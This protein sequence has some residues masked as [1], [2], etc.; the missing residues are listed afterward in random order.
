MTDIDGLI[1]DAMNKAS[2]PQYAFTNNW[3]NITARATWDW[4]IPQIDP[5]RILEIGSYEGASACY[6]IDKLAP[7]HDMAIVCVDT[8]EGSVEHKLDGTNMWQVESRF[9]RNIA[10]S[11]ECAVNEVTVAKVKGR[12]DVTMASLLSGA[13][14][15]RCDFIYIDGSHMAADVLADAVLGFKLLKVGGVMAFD[16]YTW[17]EAMP[18]G[19]DLLRCPK[20]AIDAFINLNFNN[21]ELMTTTNT[22]VFV[23]RTA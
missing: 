1:K 4:L 7:N 9:D 6:L 8:W 16:D 12:S 19:K 14:Q 10:R 13:E 23:R 21:L 15:L 22:Q 20:P 18:Y 2:T 11:I 17:V 5:H 3:F